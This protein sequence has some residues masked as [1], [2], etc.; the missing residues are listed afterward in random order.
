MEPTEVLKAHLELCS[1][2]YSLLLEENTW[3]KLQKKVPE[4]EFLQRKKFIVE[5][6]ES[7]L[8]SLKQLKPEYFSPFDNTKKLVSDSHTKLLQIFYL[9]RENEDLLVKLNQP[10]DRQSFNRFSVP[11]EQIDKIHNRS[12]SPQQPGD[13]T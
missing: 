10:I 2:V 9:D 12:S 6:L 4:M 11:P 8:A 5:K 13:Q 7:S 3:L 1:E